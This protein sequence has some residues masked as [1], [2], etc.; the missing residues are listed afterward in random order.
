MAS[1]L[2]VL[3]ISVSSIISFYFG[4]KTLLS[5][6]AGVVKQLERIL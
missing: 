3:K 1:S 2:G 6:L 5:L 4:S